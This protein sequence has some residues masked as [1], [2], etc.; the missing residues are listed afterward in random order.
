MFSQKIKEFLN[1]SQNHRD[2][3]FKTLL[4]LSFLKKI[5]NKR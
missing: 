2:L 4:A 1:K 3:R 5:K